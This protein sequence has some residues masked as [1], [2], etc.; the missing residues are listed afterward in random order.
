[1]TA[2]RAVGKTTPEDN[3]GVNAPKTEIDTTPEKDEI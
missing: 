3:R 2:Y 1:M